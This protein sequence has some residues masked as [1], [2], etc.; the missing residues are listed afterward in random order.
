M[1]SQLLRPSALDWNRT[2]GLLGLRLADHLPWECVS[3]ALR[4]GR[5]VPPKL[6]RECGN[7]QRQKGSGHQSCD[8]ISDGLDGLT[9]ER[10]TVLGGG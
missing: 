4:F 7:V 2:S 8:L 6:L 9:I 1:G 3:T 10:T 5:E